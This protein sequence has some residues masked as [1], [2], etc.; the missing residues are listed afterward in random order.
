M[1]PEIFDI[2]F[3]RGFH[4]VDMD[5]GSARLSLCGECDVERFGFEARNGETVGSDVFCAVLVE[6][7]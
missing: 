4:I 2:F 5:R 6:A 3:F 1:Q 7:M